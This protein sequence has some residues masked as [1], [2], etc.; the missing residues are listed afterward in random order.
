M[1]ERTVVI[2]NWR[3]P[4]LSVRAAESLLAD[5]VSPE[6]LVLV[7]NGSE[8]ESCETFRRTFPRS[9]VV[10]E[11]TNLGFAAG[12]NLG[13]SAR[14]ANRYLFVN[15]D[16]FVAREH[17]VERL[18]S[19][20]DAPG[21]G[22]AVPLLLNDDSTVQPSVSPLRTPGVALVQASGLSRFVP[23]RA[24]PNWST[25]WSHN[26]SRDVQNAVGA[27]IAV[28]GGLW[29]ELGGF[30]EST[31]MFG[32]DLD[33]F[34]RVR[35]H[36]R[37]LRFVHDAAFVHLGSA[38]GGRPS[39]GRAERV[40]RADATTIRR[41]LPRH[42]AALTIAFELAGHVARL[43]VFRMVGAAGRAETSRGAIRGLRP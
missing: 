12:N 13:A 2:L 40:A 37:R 3:T 14:P 32:E 39:A 41:H 27:V 31:F 15:S 28:D 6:E 19:A 16:A 35:L 30:D 21:V 18:F 1:Q 9:V 7:D 5:G 33:L 29:R 36:G 26:E 43:G 38:S 34:W 25:H 23:D 8:D 42:R 20:L 10:C 24:Q 22:A 17:S 4:D 11:K